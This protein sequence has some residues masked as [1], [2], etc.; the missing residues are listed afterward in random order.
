ML[1]ALRSTEQRA[2][3]VDTGCPAR[4]WRPDDLIICSGSGPIL[5]CID[6]I[7]FHE[8]AD[9]SRV[10]IAVAVQTKLFTRLMKP[11]LWSSLG[12]TG[13]RAL[14]VSFLCDGQ[15]IP[16]DLHQA[17]PKAIVDLPGEEPLA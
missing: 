16:E 9:L 2:D 6:A 17:S 11:A 7:G 5:T 8:T 13:K 1:Q 10:V 3:S 14:P 12:R 15:Q 4:I